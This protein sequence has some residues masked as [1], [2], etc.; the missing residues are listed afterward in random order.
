[1]MRLNEVLF[2]GA[3]WGENQASQQAVSYQSVVITD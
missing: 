1:M 3:I 2:A